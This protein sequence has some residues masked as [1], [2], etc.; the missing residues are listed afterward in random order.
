LNKYKIEWQIETVLDNGIGFG[1]NN[2]GFDLDGIHFEQWDF[3]IFEGLLENRWL[4]TGIIEAGKHID[5]VNVFYHKLGRIIPRISLVGQAYID[6]SY[7]PFLCFE[8]GKDLGMFRHTYNDH[9]GLT[10]DQSELKATELLLNDKKIPEKFFLMWNLA[11]N[12]SDYASKLLL[13]FAAID[14]LAPDEKSRKQFRLA[15]LGSELA[16]VTYASNDGL[17]HRLSHG[18]HFKPEDMKANHVEAIHKKVMEYF[19]ENIFKEKLLPLDVENPQRHI[20]GSKMA[21]Y[22]FIKPVDPEISL[23][24]KAILSALNSK[25]ELDDKKFENIAHDLAQTIFL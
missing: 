1:Q 8:V 3:N 12:V 23:S 4:A 17:R 5:A 7:Q 22:K 10:F 16:N 24:L 21:S 13:M 15:V 6:F 14:A 20:L 25:R 19:N 11:V 18:E 2:M 9:C